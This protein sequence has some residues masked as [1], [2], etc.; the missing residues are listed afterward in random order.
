MQFQADNGS[1][2][3]TKALPRPC[4]AASNLSPSHW[5]LL[6]L[7]KQWPGFPQADHTGVSPVRLLA[8]LREARLLARVLLSALCEVKLQLGVLVRFF[9]PAMGWTDSWRGASLAQVRPC[10]GWG[11][12]GP[13]PPETLLGS[14]Y[15]LSCGTGCHCAHPTPSSGFNVHKEPGHLQSRLIRRLGPGSHKPLCDT[16]AAGPHCK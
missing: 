8:S 2:N 13:C 3:R 14:A 1:L 9:A 16:E 6:S 11:T 12:G 4:P 7:L 15:L 5:A 10:E